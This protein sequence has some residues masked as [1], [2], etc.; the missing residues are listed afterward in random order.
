MTDMTYE[1]GDFRVMIHSDYW[2]SINV[3]IKVI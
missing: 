3:Y 1:R 2:I